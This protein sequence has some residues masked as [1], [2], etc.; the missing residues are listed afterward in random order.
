MLMSN[1]TDGVLK[2]WPIRTTDMGD[3][4]KICKMIKFKEQ[5]SSGSH[6]TKYRAYEDTHEQD[7]LLG[8]SG[9]EAD[10]EKCKALF[11]VDS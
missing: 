4:L 7:L 11:R 3:R 6:V 2:L 1:D 9:W 5:P 10:S 8:F